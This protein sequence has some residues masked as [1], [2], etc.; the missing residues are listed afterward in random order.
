MARRV[1][2]NNPAGQKQALRGFL[3]RE[4]YWDLQGSARVN[5]SQLSRQDRPPLQRVQPD[6]RPACDRDWVGH[7]RPHTLNKFEWNVSIA[8]TSRSSGRENRAAFGGK[9]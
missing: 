7:H 8:A 4:I 1:G 5:S 2:P 9:A 3:T 6:A